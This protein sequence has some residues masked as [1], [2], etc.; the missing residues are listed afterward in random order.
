VSEIQFAIQIHKRMETL[1]QCAETLNSKGERLVPKYHNCSYTKKRTA[2]VY[3]AEFMAERDCDL[4]CACNSVGDAEER[5]Y[6]FN[7][8]FTESMTKLVREAGLL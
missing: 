8:K 1:C 6:V 3:A 5:A 7:Q 2:L 4:I